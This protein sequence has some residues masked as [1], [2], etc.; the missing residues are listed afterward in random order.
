VGDKIEATVLDIEETLR[1]YRTVFRVI[2]FRPV[3][4]KQTVGGGSK[5]KVDAYGYPAEPTKDEIDRARADGSYTRSPSLAVPGAGDVL[6][7]KI[8]ARLN[9][10]TDMKNAL[11]QSRA[12]HRVKKM[13]LERMLNEARKK[14]RRSTIG[15]L[16]RRIASLASKEEQRA[17]A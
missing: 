14:H 2:D 4:M 7:D 8:H 3:F 15:H 1:G 12:R 16:E 11:K 9:T 6:D 17:A 5:P 10:E 13:D